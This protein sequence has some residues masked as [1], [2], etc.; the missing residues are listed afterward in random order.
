MRETVLL[1]GHGS[2]DEE[3]NQAFLAFARRVQARLQSGVAMDAMQ[4]LNR[5]NVETCFLELADPDVP[6]GVRNCAAAGSERVIA[7]PV[8]LLAASHVKLEIPELLDHARRH[9]PG[10]SIV[11]GRNVGM[12]ERVLD[13]LED[14]FRTALNSLIPPAISGT[15]RPTAGPGM[16]TAAPAPGLGTPTARRTA[17]PGMPTAAP[18]AGL[19][20]PTAALAPGPGTPP[21]APT[22][23]PG[24]PPAASTTCAT[25]G[26]AHDLAHGMDA[27]AIVLLGR[28]SSDPDANGDL[29]KL[30]RML[31]ERTGV[32]T[33]EVCFSGIT[34][35]RLPEGVRRAIRLGARRV[36]VVPYFL[37]TGVLLKRMERLLTELQAEHPDVPMC[38][39]RPLGED[40]GLVDVVIDRVVE[41]AT[42]VA[43]MN[44]DFCVYRR[45]AHHDHVHTHGHDHDHAQ[46]AHAGGGGA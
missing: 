10:L 3:G 6:S 45:A 17:G 16:P 35:P 33:V 30:A 29:Y 39:G 22:A 28:G 2:R 18:T 21:A 38:M 5:A 8:I 9:H 24:I 43:P 44:C 15:N 46:H 36:V 25:P 31:W 20:T 4:R 23:D 32:L 40:D 13:L 1:I 14:R 7:V 26:H 37:F 42:G 12:H 41:A 34:A 11:Y 19:G 27:T